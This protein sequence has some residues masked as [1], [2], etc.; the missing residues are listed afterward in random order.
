[1]QKVD[2]HISELL[3]DYDCVIVPNFGGFVTNYASAKIHP[4]QHTFT[5]PSKSIV[6]N[7]NLK[8][9][10]GLL[11]NHMAVDLNTDYLQALKYIDEFVNDTNLQLKSGK[12]VTIADVGVLFWDVEKNIQFEPSS[13]NY[14]LDSFGLVPFQS[15]AIKRDALV[16]RIEKQLKDREP[17]TLPKKK[18]VGRIIVAAVALPLVAAL[19]WI[20]LKTDLFKHTEKANLVPFTTKT[21]KKEVVA[22]QPAETVLDKDTTITRPTAPAVTP[23]QPVTE[24]MVTPVKADTTSVAILENRDGYKFHVVAGCF[25]I[26]RNAI[27]YME[28]LRQQNIDASIIGQNDKGLYV[29]SCGNF[30][31][32]KEANVKLNDLR[33]QQQTVW[34]YKK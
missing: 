30:A 9:N 24:T 32:R 18:K 14:L 13:K 34:L 17:A 15:P 22:E 29:V 21:P 25:Q 1:M 11:A 8:H 4:V 28:T 19:L 31:T 12:K 27:R 33:N 10:D 23:S 16:K 6:F 7:K 5:P 26:E 20:P 2:K 3:Y